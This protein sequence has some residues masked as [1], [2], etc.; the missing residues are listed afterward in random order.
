MKSFLGY[1]IILFF[2]F[3]RLFRISFFSILRSSPENILAIVAWEEDCQNGIPEIEDIQ[4]VIWVIDTD[5]TVD[6]AIALGEYAYERG[7]ISL[8]HIK[9]DELQ[10][11]QDIG[12][13]SSR[14]SKAIQKLL[15]IKVQMID[16]GKEGD[17]FFLHR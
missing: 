7:W 9:I 2:R 3:M 5:T 15:Q 14:C 6:D 12:W 1:Q 13:D 8:D 16:D 11:Q 17:S 4:E 10:I